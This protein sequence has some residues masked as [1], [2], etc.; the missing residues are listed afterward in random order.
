MHPLV[1]TSSVVA[2]LAALGGPTAT[3]PNHSADAVLGSPPD[4]PSATAA[5]D[6]P[7]G[8]QPVRCAD[9]HL[10]LQLDGPCVPLPTPTGPLDAR[11]RRLALAPP[12]PASLRTDTPNELVPRLPERSPRF[13]DY[14]LP[15]D[16][17]YAVDSP[18]PAQVPPQL[19]IRIVTDGGAAV[20]LVD[21]ERQI[22]QAQVVLVGDLYGM[23]VVIRQRT[24]SAEGERDH[25]V[26]YGHLDR[27]GPSVV[28][29][30]E[31]GPMA[32]VG[33]V[34]D[35]PMLE[36]HLYF[37][38]RHQRHGLDRPTRHLNQLVQSGISVAVDPR[39][40]LLLKP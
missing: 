6:D 38:V 10:R 9:R 13:A 16:P 30:A 29:G 22:G 8:R 36:P 11:S 37:E 7:L 21:L 18:D 26:F 33:Y 19:G 24:K 3:S 17:V 12:T 2:I 28:S 35:D 5:P 32:V 20:T 1:K 23:T 39:N 25:L 40:I 31:L 15:V 4:T 14:Q 34:K 27:P